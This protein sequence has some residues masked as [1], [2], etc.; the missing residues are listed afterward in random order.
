MGVKHF[1]LPDPGEGLVE[2]EIVTWKVKPGDTVKTNDIVVEIETAKSLVE[3]PIPWEG[4]V[5]E[6][7]VA[8]GTTVDVGQP[9]VSVE[10]EG[11]GDQAEPSASPE[12]E[13]GAAEGEDRVANLVGYGPSAS[14]GKRRRRK[15]PAESAGSAG[16]APGQAAE[17][18]QAVMGQAGGPVAGNAPAQAAAK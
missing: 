15:G 14:S 12:A 7:L 3:L 1:N 8:E 13:G 18:V 16:S 17:G 11:A 9:I 5:I 4:K 10:V 2:A 6:L